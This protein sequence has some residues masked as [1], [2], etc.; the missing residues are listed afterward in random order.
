MLQIGLYV[1]STALICSKELELAILGS[2]FVCVTYFVCFDTPVC[3]ITIQCIIFVTEDLIS[4][5]DALTLVNYRSGIWPAQVVHKV[6]FQGDLTPAVGGSIW[7]S[8]MRI[9]CVHILMKKTTI[10]SQGDKQL[11]LCNKLRLGTWNIRSMLQLGK[12]QL[13]GEEMMRLGADICKLSELKWDIQGH[14]TTLE[15]HTILY[16][17]RPTHGMSG[18]AVWIHRKVAG[19]LV[20]QEP[21]SD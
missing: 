19:A 18:V 3:K 21:I 9:D 17:G 4:P 5:F 12:V 15:G 10:L 8:R 14:F 13:L 11:Q 16:S 2:H 20:I 7:E 1:F 6:M